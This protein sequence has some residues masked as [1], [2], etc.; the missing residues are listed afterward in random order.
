M[1]FAAVKIRQKKDREW[2]TE[3]SDKDEIISS[4]VWKASNCSTPFSSFSCKSDHWA[5]RIM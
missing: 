4:S 3:F 5:V 1:P 2:C